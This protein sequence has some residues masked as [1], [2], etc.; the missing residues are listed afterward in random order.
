MTSANA[1]KRQ[2]LTLFKDRRFQ[3]WLAVFA[4]VAGILIALLWPKSAAYPSIGGGGY[5]LSNWVYTWAL[6]TFTGLWSLIALLV[7]MN[8]DDARAARPA[9]WLAAVGALTFVV[10]LIAFGKHVT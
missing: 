8:R 1:K 7:A 4:L 3:I 5:D 10:A 6:L 2:D 9:Y